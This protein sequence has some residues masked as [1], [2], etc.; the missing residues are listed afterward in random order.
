VDVH[1]GADREAFTLALLAKF[2]KKL[3]SVKSEEE[4]QKE[5]NVSEDDDADLGKDGGK[6]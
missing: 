1:T 2:Q 3:E 4:E 6:W 5:E